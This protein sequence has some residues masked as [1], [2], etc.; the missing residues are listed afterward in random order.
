VIAQTHNKDTPNAHG[1][2]IYIPPPGDYEASYSTLGF[3]NGTLWDNWVLQ[4]LQ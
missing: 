2:G 1:L 4:Q 3:A